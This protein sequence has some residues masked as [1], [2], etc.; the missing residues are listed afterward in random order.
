MTTLLRTMTLKSPMKFGKWYD[1]TVGDIISSKGYYGIDYL[2][3]VYYSA[4]KITFM[5][6]VMYMIGITDETQLI[7]KP[8]KLEDS[9]ELQKIAINNIKNRE[10]EDLGEGYADHVR[11]QKYVY[12][13]SEINFIK[14]RQIQEKKFFNKTNLKNRNHGK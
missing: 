2:I 4:S 13:K 3:W 11:K 1:I 7:D 12:E 9:K 8:G 14:N 5:P 10:K 6:D